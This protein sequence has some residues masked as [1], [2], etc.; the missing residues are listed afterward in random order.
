AAGGGWTTQIIL[1]NPTGIAQSGTIQFLDNGAGSTRGA[2]Q[3]V[4]ID[5]TPADTTSYSVAANSSKKFLIT[6]FSP[7]TASGSVRIVPTGSGPVPTPLVIFSYKPASVT[8]S[9]AG[10]PVV[11]GTTFRMFAQL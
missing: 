2:P 8:I 7:G 10:V 3:T 1:V 6:G 4:N 9:E 5:G 11:M